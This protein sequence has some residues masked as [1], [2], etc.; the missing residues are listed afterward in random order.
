MYWIA[1]S[2]EVPGAGLPAAVAALRAG[3]GKLTIAAPCSVALDLAFAIP[4]ARVV[5]LD[6]AA[7]GALRPRAAA[8]IELLSGRIDAVVIGPGMLDERRGTALVGDSLPMFIHSIVVLDAVAMSIVSD[9]GFSQPVILTPHAGE[10]AHLTGHLKEE[11][12][13]SPHPTVVSAA[14]RWNAAT[15]PKSSWFRL[16]RIST[17]VGCL[18]VARVARASASRCR[19][20][21]VGVLPP[22]HAPCRMHAC[23]HAMPP[24]AIR[25]QAAPAQRLQVRPVAWMWVPLSSRLCELPLLML[26]VNGPR[27]AATELCISHIGR[28]PYQ[29]R[30]MSP[31]R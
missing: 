11:V 30:Q 9:G 6:Q 27:R 28:S 13:E 21:G 29:A 14:Q 4:E 10:M 18:K 16:A 26:I 25:R 19:E 31:S 22:M 20:D 2:D 24:R 3:G 12:C 23:R 7:R 8:R 5:A 15:W 1:G 17:R